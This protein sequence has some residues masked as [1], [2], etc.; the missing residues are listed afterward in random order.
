MLIDSTK[1]NFVEKT[2]WLHTYLI[3]KLNTDL[4]SKI[5]SVEG[6]NGFEVYRQ[7]CNIVDAVP[8]NYKFFLDSQFTAMPQVYAEKI[9]GL[10]ELYGF[11]LLLK[12]KIAAYKKAI[13]HEPDHEQLKQVLYVCMDAASKNL[14]SQSGLDMRSFA[15]NCEDIDRRYKLQYE[16]LDFSKVPK[17]DDPMGLSNILEHE[18]SQSSGPPAEGPERARIQQPEMEHLDAMGKGGKGKGKNDGKC[19]Q[20][21]GDGHYVRDCPSTLLLSEVICSGCNGK[22]HY[23][24]VCPTANPQLKGGGKGWGGGGKAPWQGKGGGKGW[25]TKGKGKGGKG[26]GK[27]GGNGLYDL[28]IMSQWGGQ[29][30][31]QWGGQ[32]EEP[33]GKTP[34]GQYHR[35][36]GCLTMAAAS[37]A[38]GENLCSTFSRNSCSGECGIRHRDPVP[39]SNRFSAFDAIDMPIEC[40]IRP[41]RKKKNPM[42]ETSGRGTTGFAVPSRTKGRDETRPIVMAEWR[43]CAPALTR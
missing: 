35:S 8:A 36:L 30:D 6:K 34:Q 15:E 20:C 28:D 26:K 2:R 12:S 5:A 9:K 41:P 25:Q 21:G 39:T 37:S 22:G 10:K 1:W 32:W 33:W 14:A 13:G 17:G 40:L 4:H 19:N 31:Q 27:G 18:H 38:D 23:K 43:T 3:N 11:R 42:H 16:G 7:I 29:W 24:N